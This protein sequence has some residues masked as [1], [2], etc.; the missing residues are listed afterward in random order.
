M[1]LHIVAVVVRDDDVR[2]R[3]AH[4]VGH[5]VDGSLIVAV[6]LHIADVQVEHLFCAD[7]R[8]CALGLSRADAREGLGLNDDVPLVAVCDV[9]H[10]DLRTLLHIFPERAGAGDLQIVGVTADSQYSHDGSSRSFLRRCAAGVFFNI[11]QPTA[12]CQSSL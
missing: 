1:V 5:G 7:I 10:I 6:D 2:L 3:Y 9:A 11:G 8:A 4:H 12:V